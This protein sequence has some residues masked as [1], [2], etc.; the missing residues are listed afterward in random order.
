MDDNAR[1][2][3]TYD[4]KELLKFV[5]SVVLNGLANPF[6]FFPDLILI[7]LMP[8]KTRYFHSNCGKCLKARPHLLQNAY[9]LKRH[10]ERV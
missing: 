10:Q 9:H 4:S 3:Y 7:E 2:H 8:S 1:L 6:P 5:L